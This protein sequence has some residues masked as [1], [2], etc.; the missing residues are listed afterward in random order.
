MACNCDLLNVKTIISVL[1]GS[2]L[3]S[4]LYNKKKSLNMNVCRK[5]KMEE[6]L[7]LGK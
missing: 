6:T 3:L 7:K 4:D 1:Y 2:E 5:C